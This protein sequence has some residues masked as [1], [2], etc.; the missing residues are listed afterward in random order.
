MLVLETHHRTAEFASW[1]F[2]LLL[3]LLL[4]LESAVLKSTLK[5]DLILPLCLCV[6]L[7]VTD[8]ME[9]TLITG[10]R[11]GA[12][13]VW[14]LHNLPEL[15]PR[16]SYRAHGDGVVAAVLFGNTSCSTGHT[17]APLAASCDLEGALHVWDTE[18]V[19][20]N[21]RAFLEMT[22]CR[23]RALFSTTHAGRRRNLL[24]SYH[25]VSRVAVL[26]SI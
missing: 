6:G 24:K 13:T 4:L 26:K 9:T 12:I 22:Y 1:C 8:A 14:S 11:G 15:T 7:Q 17:V 25:E 2:H 20:R 23:C 3:F 18:T 10:H 19:Y 21:I 16:C 5:I